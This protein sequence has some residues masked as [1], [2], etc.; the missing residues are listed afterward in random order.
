MAS[1]SI[2]PAAHQASRTIYAA[3]ACALGSIPARRRKKSDAAGSIRRVLC[4]DF[5]TQNIDLIDLMFSFI[6]Q[7]DDDPPE[8]LF[9]GGVHPKY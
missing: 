3:K 1:V 4:F 2:P 5:T 9:P 8:P 7:F 6:I